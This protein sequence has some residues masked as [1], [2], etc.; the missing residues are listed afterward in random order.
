MSSL[1]DEAATTLSLFK[2][3]GSGMMAADE[4]SDLT[5]KCK[6]ITFKVHRIVVCV[7]SK[8]L[9]ACVK[10]GWKASHVSHRSKLPAN[11][12]ARD[13]RRAKSS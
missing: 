4:Y 1:P 9:A 7:Q 5:L 10:E 11:Q 13:P 6:D 2:G 3:L 12:E 8:P